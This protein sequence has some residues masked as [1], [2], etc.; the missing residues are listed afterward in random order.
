MV[1]QRT[2][3]LPYGLSYNHSIRSPFR[4]SRTSPVRVHSAGL[5]SERTPLAGCTPL[6]ISLP[7]ASSAMNVRHAATTASHACC[8]AGDMGAGFSPVEGASGPQLSAAGESSDH[9]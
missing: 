8:I 4:T 6:A 3:C 2:V 9:L 5:I 7:L 1:D